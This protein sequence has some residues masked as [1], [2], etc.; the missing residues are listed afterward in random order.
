[1]YQYD[2]RFEKVSIMV[3]MKYLFR[4]IHGFV[5]VRWKYLDYCL[6]KYQLLCSRNMLGSVCLNFCGCFHVVVVCYFVLFEFII[7]FFSVF[8]VRRGYEIVF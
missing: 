2:E 5:R 4:Y 1:M 3:I 8:R 6:G 7:A